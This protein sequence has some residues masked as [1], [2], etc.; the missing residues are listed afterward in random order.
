MKKI[1]LEAT[2]AG[3]YRFLFTKILSVIGTVW[4]PVVVLGLIAAGAVYLI[5]PH[6]WLMGQYPAVHAKDVTPEAI[7]AMCRPLVLLMPVMLVVLL[8]FKAMILTGLLRHS[9]GLKTTPTFAYF[10]LGGTVWRMVLAFLLLVAVMFLLEIGLVLLAVLFKTLA[11]PHIPSPAGNIAFGVLIAVAACFFFYAMVR[12]TFFLPAVVVAEER[13]GLGRAWELGGGN[14][15]RIFVIY[16]LV[17]LPV[18]I[19]A[20][21]IMQMTVMPAMMSEVL[22]IPHDAAPGQMFHAMMHGLRP[23]LPL[24]VGVYAVEWLAIAGLV[25]GAMGTA[26]N[27]VAAREETQAD[28]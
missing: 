8:V 23:I 28:A 5:V 9:L 12:L 15:W 11:V 25:A 19:V 20:G 24:M 21:I 26:Y 1:P 4:L 7:W 14:F 22:K 13:I 2:L 6:A 16:L 3:A 10:S 17:V 27:A 18:M